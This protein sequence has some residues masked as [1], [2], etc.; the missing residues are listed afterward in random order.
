[1]KAVTTCWLRFQNLSPFKTLFLTGNHLFL[2]TSLSVGTVHSIVEPTG[3]A[4][5]AAL[6]VAS[7][8]R[9]VAYATVA[10]VSRRTTVGIV[11]GTCRVREI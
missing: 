3:I 4:E 9:S 8:E 7:P 1:M 2:L 10:A 5:V 11:I 6:N